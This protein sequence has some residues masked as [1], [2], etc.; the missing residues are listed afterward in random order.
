MNLGTF[1]SF[2]TDNLMKALSIMGMGMLGI[3][4]VTI[5]IIA[6]VIVLNKSI[7]G[8]SASKKKSDGEN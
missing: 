3:F 2:S 5:V 1:L 8:I 6:A 4:I 7:N